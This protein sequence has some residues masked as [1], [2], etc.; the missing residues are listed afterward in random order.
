MGGRSRRS[1]ACSGRHRRVVP[2]MTNWLYLI[3][4]LCFLVGT[5]INMVKQ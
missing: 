1:G 5:I 2:D 4:S 3:G